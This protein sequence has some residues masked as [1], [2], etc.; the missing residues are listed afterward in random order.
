MRGLDLT[1]ALLDKH[2]ER[3]LGHGDGLVRSRRHREVVRPRRRLHLPAG[4]GPHG[5]VA[6]VA[7]SGEREREQ[8][9]RAT[10]GDRRALDASRP[11]GAGLVDRH[12][13][14]RARAVPRDRVGLLP[15]QGV[16]VRAEVGVDRAG[17]AHDQR[18]AATR[19]RRAGAGHRGRE[20]DRRG[21]VVGVDVSGV[22]EREGV[23]ARIETGEDRAAIR[24]GGA[25][26]GVGAGGRH[27]DAGQRR[28]RL[29][30]DLGEQ[31][32]AG[33]RRDQ[34][35]H[36]YR[37]TGIGCPVHLRVDLVVGGSTGT[38]AAAS[39]APVLFRNWACEVIV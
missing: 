25:R 6:G 37:G 27:G 15:G 35:L 9:D 33:G 36:L 31:G 4:P 21:V 22:G 34:A 28:A 20:A 30:L 10:G 23:V 1:A 29:I 8:R 17:E 16:R 7:R 12:R 11:E 14:R 26:G 13:V 38:R 3:R 2:I 19:R 18:V 32:A 24:V 39:R 5:V